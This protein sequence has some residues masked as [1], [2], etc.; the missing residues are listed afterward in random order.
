MAWQSPALA[1][2]QLIFILSVIPTILSPTAK[3]PRR[4]SILTVTAASLVIVVYATMQYWVALASVAVT[5]IEWTLIAI[6]RP[7]PD[8]PFLPLRLRAWLGE[9]RRKAIL[10]RHRMAPSKPVADLVREARH[11][12]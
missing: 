6:L 5:G 9:R 10:A 12:H 2:I 1:A 7:D 3:V 4:T 8:R 11:D